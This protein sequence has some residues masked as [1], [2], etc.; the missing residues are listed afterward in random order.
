MSH[1]FFWP[2]WLGQFLIFIHIT[3]TTSHSRNNKRKN[4]ST[5]DEQR[6]GKSKGGKR[7]RQSEPM[8]TE[9]APLFDPEDEAAALAE[10][11][12]IGEQ[13]SSAASGLDETQSQ[14]PSR[15]WRKCFPETFS[16]REQTIPCDVQ[17]VSADY[18]SKTVKARRDAR[19]ENVAGT[20]FHH[21]VGLQ[22][23]RPVPNEHTKFEDQHPSGG[24][25]VEQFMEQYEPDD[26]KLPNDSRAALADGWFAYTNDTPDEPEKVRFITAANVLNNQAVTF[27]LNRRNHLTPEAN[28]M[29]DSFINTD[30]NDFRR[31]GRSDFKAI[32]QGDMNRA[33]DGA[34][35]DAEKETLKKKVSIALG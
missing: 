2:N 20:Y 19:H 1:N 28:E 8:D 27:T 17:V 4:G 14:K 32:K 35:T 6:A 10:L 11:A 3:Q 15:R 34:I 22:S 30:I 25:T 23:G 33:A 12:Q 13:G 31:Q 7:V 26:A 29:V 16:S 9:P 5:G 18:S 21:W 24:F